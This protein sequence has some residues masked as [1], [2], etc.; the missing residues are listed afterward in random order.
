ML[1]FRPPSMSL[2]R[3]LRRAIDQVS[4]SSSTHSSSD[5]EDESILTGARIRPRG[6]WSYDRLHN[7]ED[8]EEEDEQDHS[9]SL[10]QHGDMY[11]HQQP[12]YWGDPTVVGGSPDLDT[13]L[14]AGSHEG[15]PTS[16]GQGAGGGLYGQAQDYGRPSE[17]SWNYGHHYEVGHR[18]RCWGPFEYQQLLI[19]QKLSCF[20]QLM[21]DMA[22]ILFSW[23]FFFS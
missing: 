17:A 18:P 5:G 12:Y 23:G 2:R 10:H 22:K 3:A 21:S 7:P 13:T 11:H 15:T 1:C 6:Q 19:F 8:S 16:S 14:V 9:G 20:V 4:C